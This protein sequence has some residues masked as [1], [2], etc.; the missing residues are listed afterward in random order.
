[1]RAH[2]VGDFVEL[3][4]GARHDDDVG[5]GFGERGGDGGADPASGAGDD[6]D[7]IG[8]E[9]LL[10]HAPQATQLRR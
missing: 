1:M 5:A 4:G 3:L 10:Q 7:L 8:E 6:R 9:E 2:A